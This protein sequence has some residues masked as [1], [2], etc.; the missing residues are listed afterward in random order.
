VRDATATR[1]SHARTRRRA[2]AEPAARSGAGAGD[3]RAAAD[4]ARRTDGAW[5]S[6]S[7]APCLSCMAFPVEMAL[8]PIMWCLLFLALPAATALQ[9]GLGLVR[10]RS[11]TR[12]H[13]MS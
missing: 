2:S 11:S 9:N 4:A 5:P 6:A 10:T 12:M 7:R 13:V 3:G 8:L 1:R